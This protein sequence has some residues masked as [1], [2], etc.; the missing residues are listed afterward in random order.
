MKLQHIAKVLAGFLMFMFGICHMLT[1]QTNPGMNDLRIVVN[2]LKALRT[3]S[4]QTENSIVFPNGQKDKSI[5]YVF[6]DADHKRLCYKNNTQVLLLTE[7]WAFKAD[8]RTKQ[9]SVF[10]VVKYNDRY[11]KALPELDQVFKNNLAATFMDS[12]VLKSGKIV[13]AVR[14]GNLTTYKIGF[15]AEFYVDEIA[16]VYDESKQLPESVTT[17]CFYSADASGSRG[18]GTKTISISS[19]YKAVVSEH[20]LD[21][22]QYFR[23]NG[24]KI[25]LNQYKNYKVS[26]IL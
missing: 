1:A 5:T 16:I 10:N 21:P 24:A 12:I 2:R 6:M 3:Y 19:N 14:K 13:S 25:Q 8:H 18:K 15:P 11:K 4:Y 22:G 26:S 9:A 17:S 23:V 20:D 7:K